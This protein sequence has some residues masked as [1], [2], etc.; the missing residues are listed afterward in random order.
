MTVDSR[1]LVGD[2]RLPD[3]EAARLVMVASG[4]TR[5][6]ILIG[7]AVGEASA[8]AFRRLE[9]RRLAGEPLQYLE[10]SVPFGPVVIEVDERVLIPRPETEELF[11]VV[12]GLVEEPDVIVD[13]CTGAGNLAVALASTYP[14][15]LVHA[16]DLS[17]AACDVARSNAGVNGVAV[18]VHTGDL[19]S[20]LP[21]RL[22]G[23]VDL[24][25]ANPPYLAA[26]ELEG[27]PP[28]VLREPTG[29]LVAGPKGTEV[30]ERIAAE[31]GDWLSPGGIVACEISEFMGGEVARMFS[32][33]GGRVTTDLRGRDRFVLGR[34]EV[35]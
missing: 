24:I 35:G 29:A 1:D 11:E 3:H 2:S 21:R 10:G 4:L 8:R 20:P 27:L 30:L 23:R 18:A 14:D 32:G 6:D 16:T 19:F 25:V 28:D 15:A 12:V 31:A 13:L 26:W 17:E 7:T 9:R 34:L 5:S 33:L 22:R